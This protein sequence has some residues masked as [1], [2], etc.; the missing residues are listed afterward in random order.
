[1]T[2]G[3]LWSPFLQNLVSYESGSVA[4]DGGVA[5]LSRSVQYDGHGQRK[6]F[7]IHFP[8]PLLAVNMMVSLSSGSSRDVNAPQFFCNTGNCTWP[9]VATLG[10]CS[11]CIDI[12]NRLNVNCTE[13]DI[14]MGGENFKSTS[15]RAILPGGSAG[16][17]RTGNTLSEEQLMNITQ[18]GGSDGLRYHAVRLMQTPLLTGRYRSP[19]SKSDFAATE[20]SLNP[21]VLSSLP[22]IRNGVYE[23]TPLGTFMET[24]PKNSTWLHHQLRPAWG[25]EHGIDPAANLSFGFGPTVISDWS[26]QGYLTQDPITGYVGTTDGHSAI[27]FC[28]TKPSPLGPGYCAESTI[29]SHIFNANYTAEECGSVNKDIFSC[30]MN[31]IARAITKTMRNSGVLANGTGVG[32][33]FLA[34]GQA[35]TAVTFVRVR[36][37]WIALPAGV[38]LLGFAAWVVAVTQTGRLSLP[39]WRDDPLP[40]LFLYR[41]DAQDD[42]SRAIYLGD[43]VGKDKRRDELLVGD[44][45]STWAYTK[46]SEDTHV[47]LRRVRAPSENVGGVGADTMRLVQVA[48]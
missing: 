47:Q 12:T 42:G 46:I 8:D 17:T 30:T 27:E 41:A 4:A 21:C 40:L 35:Q 37:Y 7:P 23:E 2:F 45:F 44:N 29:M 36:W 13:Y 31:G 1:M 5:L 34:A 32:G 25:L 14:V 20:C 6:I 15:C 19:I 22:S 16:L 38:W 18:V 28:S 48:D 11:R 43:P 24:P 10:F 9:P 39:T 33:A 26:S 3:M